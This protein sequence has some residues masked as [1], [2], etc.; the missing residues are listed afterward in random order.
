MMEA[1]VVKFD[2][3]KPNLKQRLLQVLVLSGLYF[4]IQFSRYSFWPSA[5]ERHRGPLSLAVEAAVVSL[6]WGVSMVSMSI[7]FGRSRSFPNYKLLVDDETITAVYEYSSWLKWRVFRR[8]VYRGNIRTI[9]EVKARLGQP[10]GM[11][12]SEKSRWC[13]RMFGFVFI[14][15]SLPEYESLKALAESWMEAYR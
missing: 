10:G 9:W 4:I 13:A 14:P 3:Y 5:T 8:S 1:Y 7:W 6:L 2:E 12:I 11:A 15:R